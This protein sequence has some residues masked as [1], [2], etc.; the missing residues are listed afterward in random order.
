MLILLILYAFHF[1]TVI[2][3]YVFSVK[4]NYSQLYFTV[5]HSYHWICFSACLDIIPLNKMFVPKNEVFFSDTISP[6]VN[7]VSNIIEIGLLIIKEEC[8]IQF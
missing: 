4:H 2:I 7:N 3:K 8:E 1:S 5:K 6:Q